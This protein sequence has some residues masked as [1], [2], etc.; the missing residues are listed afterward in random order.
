M[1]H[2]NFLLDITLPLKYLC[3]L[4]EKWRINSTRH[5]T[6]CYRC[7]DVKLLFYYTTAV[8]REI[9][10]QWQTLMLS[11]FFLHTHN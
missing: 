2:A 6:V 5:P 11:R 1:K 4:I 7:S 10:L 3:C 8:H 9:H